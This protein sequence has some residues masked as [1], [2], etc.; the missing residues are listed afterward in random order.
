MVFSS[1]AFLFLFLP[2]V[3]MLY[4]PVGN[5]RHRN[6]VLLVA[7]LFFYA[8]GEPSYIVIMVLMVAVIYALAL[9]MHKQ[10]NKAKRRAY[11]ILGV[12]FSLSFLIWFKYTGFLL[13]N[14]C[15][16]FGTKIPFRAPELPIGISF[17]TFQVL[18]YFVDVYR[19][20]TTPQRN[21]ARLLLYV[22]FFPQLIAGPIVNYSDIETSLKERTVT[23]ENVYLGMVRFIVG[24]AK[25][26][27]IANTCG[28]L[29]DA[30]NKQSFSVAGAWVQAIAFAL[31]LYFDFSGYS[32][33]AIGLGRMFGFTFKEN[34]RYPY[35]AL[36]A[37][38]FWRKWHISLGAFFRE[39]V[40]IPLGGNRVSWIKHIRNIMIVWAL[41]GIW[42]GASWNF[43]LWGLYYGILLILE[44]SF[45]LR[46]KEHLPKI[47]NCIMTL[48]V[49][50]IGWVLFYHT[51]LGDAFSHL[52]RMFGIGASGLCDPIATYEFRNSL[53]MLMIAAA[54][55]FPFAD[56]PSMMEKNGGV[57][58]K[59]ITLFRPVVATILLIL[60]V[61]M[62][63]GQSFNPFLYFRF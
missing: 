52:G 61:S 4:Y 3:M 37:T 27:I 7:S 41:T 15:G 18:T 9:L 43:L 8:Y 17:Y 51:D 28:S 63:I 44:K 57:S 11:L 26:C 23:M 21:F 39:Y 53:G 45:L 36:S 31:Q 24:L 50:I 46:V 5:R 33:M 1:A 2:L 35:T 12:L 55:C 20:K 62:I 56:I 22:S 34:F 6:A 48:F 54:A 19:G 14:I 40:Y 58:E 29:V 16:I 38:D 49:V 47:L 60:S 32:D 13:R 42:H 25:K 30:L 59:I 10:E